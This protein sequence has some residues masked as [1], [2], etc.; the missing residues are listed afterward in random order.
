MP[1]CHLAAHFVIAD[2]E[3]HD[4]QHD[5]MD[6]KGCWLVL[7]L[8]PPICWQ[9]QLCSVFAPGTPPLQDGDHRGFIQRLIDAK[10]GTA[11][12]SLRCCWSS[13]DCDTFE[14]VT[15]HRAEPTALPTCV[16]CCV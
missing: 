16:L 9:D 7:V 8:M 12:A 13:R 6:C 2:D 3:Q 11:H 1:T 14:C 10:C 5:G 15:G 4:E